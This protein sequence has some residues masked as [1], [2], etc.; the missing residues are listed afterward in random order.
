[1]YMNFSLVIFIVLQELLVRARQLMKE[2]LFTTVIIEPDNKA[3]NGD[4]LDQK[5]EYDDLP[6]PPNFKM[7]DQSFKFPRCSISTSTV[8]VLEL[9][10]EGLE[11][12]A[13]AK[14]FCSVRLFNTVRNIFE[15]WG[16]VVPTYHKTNLETLPQL[17]A[18]AHNSAMYLAHQ[19]ITL[20]FLYKDKLPAMSQHVPTFID[21]VPRLRNVG[22][23]MMLKSMRI[24]RDSILSTLGNAAMYNA[25]SERRLSSGVDQAF[26]QFIHLLNHLHKVWEPVLPLEI[27]H[28]YTSLFIFIKL[29]TIYLKRKD[30]QLVKVLTLNKKASLELFY[31][32]LP[33]LKY[34]LFP[35]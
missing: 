18:I 32:L 20:G 6:I 14:P 24:Q 7:P 17:S 16:A 19:L 10:K 35:F 21:I 29:H 30:L 15:L 13:V 27:Y 12:A 22:G 11:E 5:P 28:R 23:E 33:S 3:S 26:R 2:D 31:H 4:T 25:G 34:L 9:A 1:M 8:K